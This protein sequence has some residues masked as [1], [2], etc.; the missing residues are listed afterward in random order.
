MVKR[1]RY[2]AGSVFFDKRTRTW[3]FRWRDAGRVRRSKVLGP[4]SEL[5]TKTA[6]L[7]A[8]EVL[9]QQ[10]INIQPPAAKGTTVSELYDRYREERMPT[11][12]STIRGYTCWFKNHILPA[13]GVTP[14]SGV[15]PREVELWLNKLSLAPKSRVHIRCMLSQLFEYA[16]WADLMP[17]NRNPMSLVTIRNASKRM[18]KPRV[19]SVEEFQRLIA[20]L[21]EPYR[22]IA[23]LGGCL[24]LRISEVLGLQWKD[25]DWLNGELR[26]ERAV[27]KQKTG[28]VKT[29]HSAKPLPLDAQLLEVLKAHKQR[30]DFTAPEE[31]VFASPDQMG[32]LPRSYSCICEKLAKA[33][34]RAGVGHISTHSFRHSY[35]SWLDALGTPLS[36]QQ[37]AMRHGDIRI[38]MNTYGDLIGDELRLAHSRVVG[39]VI[40]P[41]MDRKPS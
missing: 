1:T 33:G 8:V 35:R 15:K 14:L 19:L 34:K 21:T 20:I 9:R 11:H 10:V 41:K 13:W 3:N 24:G 22:T 6:A 31:W 12:A 25:I 26:L 28:E 5:P 16:M 36:V 17:A 29:H 4:E 23:I 18:N 39:S 27:V 40:G 38:T 2:Q 32:K 7:K 30:S 37:R